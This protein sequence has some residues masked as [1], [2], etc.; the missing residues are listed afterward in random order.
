[1]TMIIQTLDMMNYNN[2]KKNRLGRA[3][4]GKWIFTVELD[5]NIAVI[6]MG[7]IST[8]HLILL[9][10]MVETCNISRYR[11][12]YNNR[13]EALTLFKIERRNSS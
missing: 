5:G 8:S 12:R 11:R 13:G 9:Q 2:I 10:I 3:G 1:M 4:R 7:R 6:E